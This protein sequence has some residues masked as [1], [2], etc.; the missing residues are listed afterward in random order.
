M[1]QC[2]GRSGGRRS[3][4][5][6]SGD[7]SLPVSCEDQ[8]RCSLRARGEKLGLRSSGS[9]RSSELPPASLLAA[10]W[11]QIRPQGP[12]VAVRILVQS[13][14]GEEAPRACRD[15][16]RVLVWPGHFAPSVPP[17]LLR[18]RAG[19]VGFAPPSPYRTPPSAPP[20][21]G[22]CANPR[23][24]RRDLAADPARD[25]SLLRASSALTSQRTSTA[26]TPSSRALLG[27]S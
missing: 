27:H 12:R 2:T 21:L 17:L 20:T 19:G 3:S 1:A 22:E 13:L 18:H 15:P 5:T 16:R 4:R 11:C 10:P 23:R 7:R 6:G 26:G 14:D 8:T 25:E 24:M 9:A